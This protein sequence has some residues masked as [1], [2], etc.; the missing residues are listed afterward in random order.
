MEDALENE[1]SLSFGDSRRVA[2][3]LDCLVGTVGK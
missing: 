2:V 1:L 3:S